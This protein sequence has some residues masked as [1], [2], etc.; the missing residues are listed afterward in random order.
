MPDERADLLHIAVVCI[1][2]S[3]LSVLILWY[4]HAVLFHDGGKLANLGFFSFGDGFFFFAMLA[5][6]LSSAGVISGIGTSDSLAAIWAPPLSI[7]I[8]FTFA[9]HM[10]DAIKRPDERGFVS[11]AFFFVFTSM[12][13]IIPGIFTIRRDAKEDKKLERHYMHAK[14]WLG[15]AVISLLFLLV[16]FVQFF[17]VSW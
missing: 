13:L 8:T 9:W 16:A 6:Y 12:A 10:L 1:I 4:T 14:L 7:L 11:F 5:L 17:N 3:I 2:A 15:V